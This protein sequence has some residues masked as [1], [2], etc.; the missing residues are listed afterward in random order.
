MEEKEIIRDKEQAYSFI[1][2]YEFNKVIDALREKYS[3][4][5]CDPL[6]YFPIVTRIV[7]KGEIK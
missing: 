6:P 7:L 5:E 4:S 2:D 3:I 1:S